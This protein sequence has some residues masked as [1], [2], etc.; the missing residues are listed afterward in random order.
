MRERD[1]RRA[2]AAADIDDPLAGRRLGAINQDVE[3]R[4]QQ[5]VLR[6]LP[7]GPALPARPVPVGDLVGVLFV[8]CG[9]IHLLRLSI[10]AAHRCCVSAQTTSRV[11]SSAIASAS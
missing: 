5:D 7:V 8:A 9:C 10:S 4:P 3:D 2:A 1:R 6:S 11:R